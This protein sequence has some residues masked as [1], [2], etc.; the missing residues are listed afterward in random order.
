MWTYQRTDEL[1]HHGIL[2]MK[3]GVRRYQNADGSLTAAGK[4]RYGKMSNDAREA[5]NI[6]KKKVSEMSNEEL[7]KLNNRKQLEDN[8]KR[9]NP[10]KAKRITKTALATIGTA[11]T[12]ASI[13]DMGPKYSK[14]LE[15]GRSTVD[16]LRL[17]K[18]LFTHRNNK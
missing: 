6:K 16:Y 5:Y 18:W 7:R 8:Y 2:G 14:L 4:K 12:I 11:A 1:Y 9:L 10:S 17:Q 15:N 3:W 13:S